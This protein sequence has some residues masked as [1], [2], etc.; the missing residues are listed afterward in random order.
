MKH[1]RPE[2]RRLVESHCGKYWES[3]ADMYG[4]RRCHS[5]M[6]WQAIQAILYVACLDEAFERY[7]W[8]LDTEAGTPAFLKANDDLVDVR[9]LRSR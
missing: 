7:T 6:V 4:W 5:Q 9:Q 2:R 3:T 8:F 1:G